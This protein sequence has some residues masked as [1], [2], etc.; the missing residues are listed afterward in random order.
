V[1]PMIVTNEPD[2]RKPC[3]PVKNRNE[4]GTIARMLVATLE[5]HNSRA[6]KQARIGVTRSASIGVGLSAPQIGVHKRVCL[7]YVH[8]VPLV[9]MNPVIVDHSPVRVPFDEGC[10]SFP[11]EEVDTWRH[12]WVTVKTMNLREPMTFGPTDPSA[13]NATALLR[14]VVA[15]HEIAHLHGLLMWDFS[16]KEY[17]PPAEWDSWRPAVG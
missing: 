5:R 13:V 4:G 12:L 17:P 11:G 1:I 10:L 6:R 8:E 7:I 14:S 16:K 2:L 15:Q 9:L 3:E